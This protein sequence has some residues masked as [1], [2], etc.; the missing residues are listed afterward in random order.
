MRHLLIANRVSEATPNLSPS[1]AHLTLNSVN[2]DTNVS[3][4]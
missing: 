1:V 4:E 3:S 2:Y